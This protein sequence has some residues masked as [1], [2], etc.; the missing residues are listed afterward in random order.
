VNATTVTATFNI[1]G[2]APTGTRNLDLTT[3][4]NGTSNTVSFQVVNPPAP[5]L[6][7]VAPNT[8]VRGTAVAVTLTGAN[9]TT[10]GTTVAVSGS[11]GGNINIS[12]VTVVSATQITATFTIGTGATLGGHT[13]TV[14][15]SGGTSG[16]QTFTVQG[17]T[18]A[19][20]SP[21]SGLRGTTV[22]ATLS[23]ANL[24]GATAVNVSGNGVTCTIVP[25]ATSS[26]V[27]ANC[28][29]ASGA[30][31]GNRNVQV[32]TPIG[33]TNNVTFGVQ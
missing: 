18:L 27:N 6:T 11:G 33:T 16:G 4:N 21:T 9:F 2:S 3:A 23:G 17:P 12:G 20:I 26:T 15:T 19:S 8:G 22:P 13:V 24:T 32:V 10:T 30:T 29:I 1:S 31:Q 7:S 14:T 5:T 25:P 28:A